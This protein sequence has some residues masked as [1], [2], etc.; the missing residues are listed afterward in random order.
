MQ[1]LGVCRYQMTNATLL[2]HNKLQKLWLKDTGIRQNIKPDVK[3]G[4]LVFSISKPQEHQVLPRICIRCQGLHRAH[5]ECKSWCH[6][7]VSHSAANWSK[8]ADLS[9]KTQP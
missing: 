6:Y 7:M 5:T 3:S 9:H 2:I 8:T 4:N 1:Y